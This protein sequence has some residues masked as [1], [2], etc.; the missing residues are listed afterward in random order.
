MKTPDFFVVGGSSCGTTALCTY[1]TDHP[2]ICF[3]RTKEPHFFSDDFPLQRADHDF[4]S[5]WRRNFSYFDPKTHVVLGEGSGTYYVSSVAIPNILARNPAAKFIYMVRDPVEMI[6]SWHYHVRFGSGVTDSLEE[7]WERWQPRIGDPEM[8][9]EDGNLRF[10]QYR[11]LGSLGRRLEFIKSIVPADQLMVIVFDDFVRDTKTVY[12]QVLGFI[13]APSDGR[14]DFP[15][16]NPARLQRSYV[17]GRITRSI[18]KWVVNSAREFKHLT[19]LN[20]V[21][22]NVFAMLNTKPV[23]RAELSPAFRKRLVAEFEP[24]IQLLEKHLARD[25][26]GWRAS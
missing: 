17:L 26:N 7:A 20:H 19:G 15:R 2:N 18:P 12:E 11:A 13:G 21:P 23:K 22:M 4:E 16:V 6:H 5:Y 25:F 24:E 10:R 1:L 8:R 9:A 14:T 3:A